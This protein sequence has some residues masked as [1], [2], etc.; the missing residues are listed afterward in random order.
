[1]VISA[2]IFAADFLHLDMELQIIRNKAQR[3]HFDVIDGYF[4]NNFGLCPSILDVI[5]KNIDIP[6]D[7]H[8]M[9]L[10]P[11]THIKYFNKKNIDTIYFHLEKTKNTAEIISYIKELGIKVGIALNPETPVNYIEPIKDKI[12]KILIMTV[13]PGM[14]GQTFLE[15]MIPKINLAKKSFEKLEI[16]IDGGVTYDIIKS[17]YADCYVMGNAF[18]KGI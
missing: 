2:S 17:V 14:C 6:I 5:Q 12:D 8:L 10:D 9:T 7:L 3:I 18:F 13:N 15:G 11:K 1:M 4:A 16:S